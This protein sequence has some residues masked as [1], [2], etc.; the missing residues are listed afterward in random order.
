MMCSN[1][2]GVLWRILANFLSRFKMFANRTRCAGRHM[3]MEHVIECVQ[4]EEGKGKWKP[5][6]YAPNY[7]SKC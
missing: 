5:K 7:S 1:N 3:Q 2:E 6:A 4:F